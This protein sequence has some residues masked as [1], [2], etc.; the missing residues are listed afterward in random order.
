VAQWVK[1][2]QTYQWALMM[3]FGDRPQVDKV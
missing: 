2:N 3:T 1:D